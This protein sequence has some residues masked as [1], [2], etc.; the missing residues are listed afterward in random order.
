M[1]GGTW[2]R[3]GLPAALTSGTYNAANQQTAFGGTTQTFDLNGNLTSDG[4]LTYTWDARNRL[5]GLSGGATASFQYD[6]LGRR[7]SKTIN[8][9][10]TGFLYDWLNPVQEL[11]GSTPT[12]NLLTGLGID[13]YLTRTDSTATRAYLADA[14][15]GISALTDNSGTVQ[16]S[17]TYE[18]FGAT[19][20]TGSPGSNSLDYTSRES[21]GTGL[22]YYRARYYHPLLQRFVSADPIGF[23]GG[24]VNLYAYVRNSPVLRVD[25]TGL[26]TFGVQ[27]Q[28]SGGAVGSSGSVSSGIVMDDRGQIGFIDTVGVG[29][30]G[31]TSLTGASLLGQIAGSTA[32]TIQTLEGPGASADITVAAPIPVGGVVIP[33]AA[34]GGTFVGGGYTGFTGGLGIGT[35]G[36]ALSGQGTFTKVRCIF[37]C[38][39]G[40]KDRFNPEFI[41][42]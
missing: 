31:Q 40:R 25:P 33:V 32:P 41:M 37:N 22:K 3:T 11:N 42:P 5:A 10:Q 24:D 26:A 20:T 36:V 38:M 34:Q 14:L 6:P 18:P 12:A 19:S 23:H 16:V 2:A 28:L 17:Y 1:V 39:G 8:G 13:E 35:P 21:D 7:T 4:T 27:I 29:G 30:A 9:T 15:G